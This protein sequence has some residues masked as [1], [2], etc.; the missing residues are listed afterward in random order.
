MQLRKRTS[1][2]SQR[3]SFVFM[4]EDLKGKRHPPSPPPQRTGT[5]SEKK[6]RRAA[7]PRTL[8]QEAAILGPQKVFSD[9]TSPN[10]SHLL[11]GM[12]KVYSFGVPFFYQLPPGTKTPCSSPFL[13]TCLFQGHFFPFPLFF[14]SPLF[15]VSFKA[16]LLP[17]RLL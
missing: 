3:F 2:G 13:K 4:G 6:I 5:C 7:P 14:F 17:L 12:R 8:A 11:D 16:W 10:T 1:I 15:S 9:A